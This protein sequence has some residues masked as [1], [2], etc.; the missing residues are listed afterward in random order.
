MSEHIDRPTLEAYVEQELA[1]AERRAV[2]AHVTGCPACQARLA[3]AKQLPAWLYQLP[4]QA[5]AANL[6]ARINAAVA[7]LR[8]PVLPVW[9]RIVMP[10]SFA[11]GLILLGMTAP[12][13]SNWAQSLAMAQ[14]P[15]HALWAWLC[16]WL[17]DPLTAWGTLAAGVEQALVGPAEEMDL[18]VTLAA[19]VLTV[20]SVMGLAQLLSGE[21]PTTMMPGVSA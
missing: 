1:A 20:A 19:V 13:W 8:A 11:L 9:V 2:E 12:H 17:A 6:A 15:D 5:P 7:A 4:R 3:A 18:L 16:H 10:V 14:R 21:R